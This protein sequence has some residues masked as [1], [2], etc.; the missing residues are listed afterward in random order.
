MLDKEKACWD[1]G[2]VSGVVRSKA[3]PA[4][5]AFGALCLVAA[6]SD[7]GRDTGPV[8]IS[9]AIVALLTGAVV[10]GLLMTPVLEWDDDHLKTTVL[11]VRRQSVDLHHLTTI[12]LFVGARTGAT[13]T[14]RDRAGGRLNISER[15]FNGGEGWKAA[16]LAGACRSGLDLDLDVRHWLESAV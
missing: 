5:V 14:L 8:G 2:D 1:G 4:A 9:V 13:C 11:F 15:L 7:L 12:T 3:M 10:C 16:I 6:A